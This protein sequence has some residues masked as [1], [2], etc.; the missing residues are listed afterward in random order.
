MAFCTSPIQAQSTASEG[1]QSN[2]EAAYS[3]SKSPKE[4]DP[5]TN[6]KRLWSRFQNFRFLGF[7]T[8]QL[9]ISVARITLLQEM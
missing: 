1:L 3:Q 6:S 8:S 5:S 2:A 9:A 7:L 4:G